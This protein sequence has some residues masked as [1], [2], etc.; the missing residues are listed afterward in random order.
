MAKLPDGTNLVIV[1]S[2][3][4]FV[5]P[6]ILAS[7]KYGGLNVHP[8]LLPD[9]R[10]PAPIHHALLRGDTHMGVSLQTLDDRA[11]DHGT[12]LAQSPAPGMPI[13]PDA[14]FQEVLSAAAVKGAEMLIQG[15]RDGVHVAPREDVGW[16]AA[17]L[18]GK[19]LVHAPKITKADGQIHWSAWT[20]E[21]F[22]RRVRVL[23][24][25]WTH[26]VSDRGVRKRVIFLDATPVAQGDVLRQG[27]EGRL[28]C[29]HEGADEKRAGRHEMKVV[30]QQDGSCLIGIPGDSWIRVEKVKV[31]GKPEQMA[32]IALGSFVR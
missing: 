11:F 1:V 31:D 23:G 30:L 29:D 5:P 3:G 13:A 6:R 24:S 10:G 7:A 9:L 25:V 14:S 12:V 19:Q 21:Q 18:Q 16:K 17:A 15:L 27:G 8:S 22:A 2:F 20:A 32:V 28:V 4:L 26:A